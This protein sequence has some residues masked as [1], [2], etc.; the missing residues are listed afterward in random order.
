MHPGISKAHEM[1][2]AASIRE[3]T[4][5]AGQ[6]ARI[7][8]LRHLGAGPDVKDM[9][10]DSPTTNHYYPPAPSHPPPAPSSPLVPLAGMA[11]IA[12]GI[13]AA[14]YFLRPQQA[15]NPATTPDPATRP[16]PITTPP[17][18]IVP[19]GYGIHIYEP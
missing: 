15:A 8:A 4:D 14:G 11:L 17:A 5:L 10:V 18:P 1:S 6:V 3:S 16:A 2:T 7:H 9:V 12:A 19:D 13:A